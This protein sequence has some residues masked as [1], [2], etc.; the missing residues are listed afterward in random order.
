ML[1]QV[2]VTAQGQITIPA[3]IRRKLK[4]DNAKLILREEGNTIVMEPAP[5]ILSQYG[6]LN[7]KAI[8]DK[9]IEDVVELEEQILTDAASEKYE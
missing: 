7:D 4:L 1:Y 6:V 5:D 3:Q 8:Q 2:T 9:S